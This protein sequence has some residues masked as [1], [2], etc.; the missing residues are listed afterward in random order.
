MESGSLTDPPVRAIPAVVDDLVRGEALVA[1]GALHDDLVVAGA[2]GHGAGGCRC[3]EAGESQAPG[4]A[5]P[6]TLG[7][8]GCWG[9]RGALHNMLGRGWQPDRGVAAHASAS[10]TTPRSVSS[11]RSPMRHEA[12]SLLSTPSALTWTS[13]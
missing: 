6:G 7:A 12:R 3:L 8:G 1:E 2:R 4:P 5:P 13:L 11:S 9:H 10:S